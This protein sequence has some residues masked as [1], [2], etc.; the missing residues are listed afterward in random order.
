[1]TPDIYVFDDA[2]KLAY[3]GRI[4]DNWQRPEKVTQRELAAALDATARRPA[5]VAG[6]ASL[7]RLLEP[8]TLSASTSPAPQ[9]FAQRPEPPDSVSGGR[10]ASSA[11]APPIA[12]GTP[13]SSI[14]AALTAVAPCVSADHDMRVL[15][16]RSRHRACC[17]PARLPAHDASGGHRTA[18]WREVSHRR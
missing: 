18:G 15:L 7:D 9:G 3:H 12:Q 1:C 16:A 10:L 4:D 6:S 11:M 8:R 5:A 14:S 13:Q 2:Q 17:P